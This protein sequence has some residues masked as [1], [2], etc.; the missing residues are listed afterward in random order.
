MFN[1]RWKERGKSSHEAF[2]VLMFPVIVLGGIYLGIFTALECGA[3]AVLYAVIMP[4]GRRILKVRDIPRL[5]ADSVIAASMVTTIILGALMMGYLFTLL[6]I[7]NLV[8]DFISGLGLGTLG[9]MMLLVLF[10]LIIGMF[11]EVVAQLAITLPIVHPLVISL[12]FDG[13]WFGVFVTILM[14]L[15]LLTP[16]VGLNL[17]VIQGVAKTNIWPV[18]R[19]TLPFWLL[20]GISMVIIYI[21]PQIV[22]WLPS[23]MIR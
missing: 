16:P 4:L 11:L 3:F 23:K 10:Y 5:I 1:R 8:F 12:G 13:V 17:Y 9:I 2:W 19:G 7:P 20:L 21:F 15:S 6:R 22:L 18:I 14:E